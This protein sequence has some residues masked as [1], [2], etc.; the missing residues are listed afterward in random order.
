MN[1]A[2]IA[3]LI[4]AGAFATVVAGFGL[5]VWLERKKGLGRIESYQEK[6]PFD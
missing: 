1:D 6:R 3:L 4:L 2:L 5:V